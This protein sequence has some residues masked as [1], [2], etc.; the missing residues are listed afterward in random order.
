MST[1]I[2]PGQVW[3][4]KPGSTSHKEGTEV[5]ITSA[6]DAADSDER[7]VWYEYP[8]GSQA[9]QWR[10]RGGFLADMVFVRDTTPA[11][12]DPS[13]VKAGDTVTVSG[14]GTGDRPAYQITGV[15]WEP[16][17]SP[18]TLW[19]GPVCISAPLVILTDHQPAPE[20]EKD[21]LAETIWKAS[22][23]DEGTISATGA[24]HVAAAI[25]NLFVVID[26]AAVDESEL[27]SI[28][29]GEYGHEDDVARALDT[30]RVILAELGVEA[31]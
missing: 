18:G 25:R 26:P 13:K 19:V 17:H 14:G 2:K 30:V 22:R 1:E 27:A 7:A 5:L 24:N 28:I 16:S 3:A 29:A 8:D 15:A 11:P 21:L 9:A 12:L 6:N 23:A 31:S 4:W 20:P 10:T